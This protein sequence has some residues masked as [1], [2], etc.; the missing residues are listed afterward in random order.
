MSS[1]RE[2]DLKYNMHSWTAQ[3]K[4]T[5]EVIVKAQGI[6]LWN[7]E[8]KQFYDM[9]SQLVNMNLG[10]GHKKIIKAIQDQA[11]KLAFISPSFTCDVRSMAAKKIVEIA[12]DNMA[13]VF[14][15]NAGAESNE[16]AIK[17]AKLYNGRYKIFS[18][19][20][21][22][23]GSSYGAGNLSGEPRR[24]SNEPGIPGFVKFVGPYTY[25]APKG[26]KFDSE[27]DAAAYYLEILEDQI[28]YEGSDKISA[29]FLETVVGSNGILIPPKGYLE[30]VRT[31]CDKYGILM[32]A[33]EVMTGWGRTGTWFAVENFN[34]KPD[35]ITFAKGSTCGYVPLGG[36]II[37]KEIAQYFD[38]N[39]LHCGLTYSAHPIGCAAAIA[40]LDAYTDEHVFDNVKKVGIVLG[41]ILEDLKEKHPSVGD[42][43]YIGLFSSIELV[44]DK[45]TREPLVP[46]AKDPDGIMK[47]ITCML[48]QDGFLTYTHENIII[49]APPLII[50]EDQLKEAMKIM[51]NVLYKVDEMILE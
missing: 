49:I 20:R 30:G 35:I 38:D 22:Y 5:P 51:D 19:Y 37:S 9:S 42:V 47:K 12:P 27:E 28:L 7:D 3:S 10:H 40:T 32:V 24:F 11:E 33:D 45:G 36:V 16:N 21:S 13:K 14:F 18:A 25:R 17:I 50:T 29:I 41:S 46:F 43:R 34:V 6:F 8:G 31:L 44:K 39:V 48:R 4:C 23:H 1:I 15:T 2:M 26:V